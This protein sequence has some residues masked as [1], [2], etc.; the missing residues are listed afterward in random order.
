MND[1]LEF[2]RAFVLSGWIVSILLVCVLG[3]ELICAGVSKVVTFF[4][5]RDNPNEP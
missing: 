1:I 5:R 2:A 3:L 4:T